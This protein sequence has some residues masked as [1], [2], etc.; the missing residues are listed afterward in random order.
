MLNNVTT[1]T[2]RYYGGIEDSQFDSTGLELAG[3]GKPSAALLRQIAGLLGHPHLA[4][5]HQALA[6]QLGLARIYRTRDRP[7]AGAAGGRTRLTRRGER[8]GRG[9]N[10]GPSATFPAQ[11]RRR[12]S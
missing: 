7:A 9:A 8:L 4:T 12:R 6:A 10:A 3:G 2:T 5:D 11:Q 1:H